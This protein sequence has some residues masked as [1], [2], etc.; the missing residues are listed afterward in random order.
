MNITGYQPMNMV[1]PT[2]AEHLVIETSYLMQTLTI[3]I[4][5]T[6]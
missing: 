4:Q 1:T 6:A 2:G 3:N 5:V